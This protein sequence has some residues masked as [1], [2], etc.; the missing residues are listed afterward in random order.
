LTQSAY[1]QII[2]TPVSVLSD[3]SQMLIGYIS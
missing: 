3:D 2:T 1:Y